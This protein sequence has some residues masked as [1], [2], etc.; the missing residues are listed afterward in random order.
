[1]RNHRKRWIALAGAAT[2]SAAGLL[3]AAGPAAAG[4]P[5]ERPAAQQQGS[6]YTIDGFEVRYLPPGL[7]RLGI[8]AV[9]A[10]D[11][12]GRS[13]AI[14][15]VASDRVHGRVTVVRSARIGDVEDLRAA[16]YG[17][18]EDASLKRTRTNGAAAYLSERT[19][20]MFWVPERGVGVGTYLRPARWDSGEL[21][22][23]SA[24]VRQRTEPGDPGQDAQPGGQE[25]A[26]DDG[27]PSGPVGGAQGGDTAAGTEQ[28]GAA[29]SAEEPAGAAGTQAP[30][31]E[32]VPI[33]RIA[34]QRAA[35]PSPGA[36]VAAPEEPPQTGA[37]PPAAASGDSGGAPPGTGAGGSGSA[38]AEPAGTGPDGPA[39]GMSPMAV[40]T[41]LAEELLLKESD[42][43]PAEV[44]AD[45]GELLKLWR[46]VG[47]DTQHEAAR[48]CA[49]RLGAET[50][51]VQQVVS[52]LDTRLDEAVGPRQGARQSEH[53]R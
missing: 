22:S 49:A 40:R 34:P 19:G 13:S 30:P 28:G 25:G 32:S 6:T 5:G 31:E 15:W 35:D 7:Q 45:S 9:S 48:V 24:G 18:L 3:G 42:A 33:R 51:Q 14:S 8:H 38:G 16:R 4:G 36:A 47:S 26:A 37:Q 39:S 2:L 1:M 46:S 27:A 10:A 44:A 17:H 21:A 43:R 50:R 53:A 41:C 29:G 23:F 12:D 52:A 11:A 20:E